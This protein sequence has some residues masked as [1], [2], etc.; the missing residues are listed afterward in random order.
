MSKL[1][2][3]LIIV[4]VGLQCKALE[5]YVVLGD[6]GKNTQGQL[7][8]SQAMTELCQKERCDLGLLLG[9]NI[10]EEGM[11]SPTD[12][13]LKTLFEKYYQNLPFKFL[14]ALGNHDY[15]KLSNDWVRGEYQVQYART[16]QQYYLPNFFYTY[17]TAEAQ[18]VV[19]DSS[20]MMWSKDLQAQAQLVQQAYQ[21]KQNKWFIVVLHH[22]YLSNGKHGN[23]GNYDNL[24]FPPMVAGT[25]VKKFIEKNI[26]GKADVIFSGHD[27]NLQ[28][29]DGTIKNCQ[30][31]L[32]V[33]GSG[34]STDKLTARNPVLFASESLGF[35]FLKLNAE[36]AVIETRDQ[37]NSLLHSYKFQK[38]N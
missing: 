10:Y 3:S 7:E 33:S 5:N 36:I 23:A 28:L 34:A 12:P 35:H 9:D 27:H 1:K 15:G 25:E 21:A 16:N 11:T 29:I 18:I 38:K 22:P 2:L 8:V 26:C 4:F 17:A 6:T 31:L 24:S 30:S 20:R 14:V 37:K 13:I 32:V 19:L